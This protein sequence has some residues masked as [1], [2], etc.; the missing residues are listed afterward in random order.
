[1]LKD[2]IENVFTGLFVTLVVLVL[3]SKL[4]RILGNRFGPPPQPAALPPQMAEQLTQIQ[5]SVDAMATEIERISESQRF[6]TQL[7]SGNA[8]AAALPRASSGT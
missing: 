4:L 2:T 3:G 8:E 5:H 1:M 7:Q 6:L